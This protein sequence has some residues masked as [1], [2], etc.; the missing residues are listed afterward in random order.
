MANEIPAVKVLGRS[1]LQGGGHNTIGIASNRKEE[2]WGEL[3]GTYV[4]N[5]ALF[6]PRDIG[7]AGN[8]LGENTFDK[9]NLTVVSVNGGT[10][11][12]ATTTI[13]AQYSGQDGKILMT[14]RDI[15]GAATAAVNAQ[16]YVVNF[17]AIG[18]SARNPE[19]T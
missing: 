10:E 5:G 9:L 3:S 7:L 4:T 8:A 11:V 13:S 1:R 6:K 18:D 15:N 2:V 12:T 16:A 17:H 19:L 14:T